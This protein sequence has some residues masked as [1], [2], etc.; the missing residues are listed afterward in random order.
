MLSV[1]FSYHGM[2]HQEWFSEI[3]TP[4]EARLVGRMISVVTKK[5]QIHHISFSTTL[6]LWPAKI[7]F[8]PTLKFN[9]APSFCIPMNKPQHSKFSKREGMGRTNKHSLAIVI[10]MQQMCMIQHSVYKH[11]PWYVATLTEQQVMIIHLKSSFLHAGYDIVWVFS[12]VMYWRT[13]AS[14]S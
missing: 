12:R 13:I 4:H 5:G 10:I 14:L 6:Q 9:N 11:L 1:A 8:T 3:L 2:E 7:S